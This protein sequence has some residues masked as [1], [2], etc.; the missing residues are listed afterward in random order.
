VQHERLSRLC[1]IDYDKEMAL[2]AECHNPRSGNAQIIGVGRL[3][4]LHGIGEAEF[5]L[6]IGDPWQGHGL[7]TELLKMLVQIGRDEK[8]QR[9]TG[10]ILAENSAMLKVAAKVGFK[11][12]PESDP[13]ERTVALCL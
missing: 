6:V 13:S 8:L 1:F 3:S 12:Q 7:G 4:K 10:I 11:R 9:I 5:A 2:I